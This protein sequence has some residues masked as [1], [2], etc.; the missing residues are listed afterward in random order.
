L[1]Q[2]CS[3]ALAIVLRGIFLPESALSTRRLEARAFVLDDELRRFSVASAGVIR[4]QSDNW[5]S[6]FAIHKADVTLE[7]ARLY[8][9]PNPAIFGE[10]S[11]A[12]VIATRPGSWKKSAGSPANRFEKRRTPSCA[13]SAASLATGL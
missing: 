12:G 9:Q 13:R 6:S 8:L 5:L 7:V 1:F 4:R 3:N 10:E 11:Q 2:E